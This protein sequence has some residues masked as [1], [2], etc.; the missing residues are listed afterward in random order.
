MARRGSISD[1]EY[2]L[3]HL[4]MKI[5][6]G[7]PQK[8]EHCKTTEKRM[9]HWANISGTYLRQRDDW[10]RLCVP[11]HKKHDVKALGGKVKSR[12]RVTQPTKVCDECSKVFAKQPRESGKQWDTKLYCSRRC[13]TAVTGRKNFG[14]RQSAE[15]GALKSQKLRERWATNIEWRERVT[16]KMQGNQFAR[17][18]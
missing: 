7:K 11:C 1:S 10:L 6:F 3:V 18:H 8:C 4:W 9:Y 14:K 16:A 2:T 12:I 13:S 5:T 17:K 15:T